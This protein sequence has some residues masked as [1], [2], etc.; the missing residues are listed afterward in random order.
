VIRW[1]LYNITIPVEVDS[2]NNVIRKFRIKINLL[3]S[4]RI[5]C[6]LVA[7]QA[8]ISLPPAGGRN[9]LW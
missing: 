5:T 7:L 3:S 4:I 8:L 1:Q 6:P 9:Y 2:P